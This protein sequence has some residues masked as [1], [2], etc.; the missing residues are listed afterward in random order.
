[1]APS[2]DRDLPQGPLDRIT[3]DLADDLECVGTNADRLAF[4]RIFIVMAPKLKAYLIK[5]GQSHSEA[6]EIL[7]DTMLKVWRKAVLFDRTKSGANTWIYAIAKNARIDRIRK[8][9]KP[10]PDPQDPSFVPDAPETGERS[11]SRK[12]DSELIRTAMAKLPTEQI[13]IIK[14]SFFEDKSHAEISQ[15]LDLPLGTV[16]SRIRLA[17]G[18]IRSEVE[19]FQ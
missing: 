1:M 17:F 14:M 8:Q 11:V 13:Q 9:T 2:N 4:R 3:P 18:K 10:V 19:K 15:E 7:Q 6:E 12:Q 5:T 16:K